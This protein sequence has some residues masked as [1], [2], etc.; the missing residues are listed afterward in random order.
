M[1]VETDDGSTAA[2]GQRREHGFLCRVCDF[3]RLDAEQRRLD[4][5][6]SLCDLRLE[7]LSL[8]RDIGLLSGRAASDEASG[9]E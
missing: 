4:N 2:I 5:R 7:K 6:A 1:S 3:H 9:Q 8:L